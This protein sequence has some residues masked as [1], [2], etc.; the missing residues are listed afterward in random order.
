MNVIYQTKITKIG[1]FAKDALDENMLITFKEGAP[2]DVEDYCFIHA[3]GELN[4]ELQVGDTLQIDNEHFEISAVG[5][6]ASF[7]L[8]ELGHVTF[9]FDGKQEAEYPGTIHLIG[10][11]PQ[12]IDVNTVLKINRN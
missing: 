3:H 8:K 2:Q 9:R 5:N 6:V 7:N 4:G 11:V 12:N 10:N 1:Q